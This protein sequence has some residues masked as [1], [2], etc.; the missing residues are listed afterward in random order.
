M[1]FPHGRRFSGASPPES[2]G[3]ETH[4]VCAEKRHE[5]RT[6]RDGGAP[7][8]SAASPPADC[9]MGTRAPA[10]LI[11][12]AADFEWRSLHV[13]RTFGGVRSLRQRMHI[14][15]RAGYSNT[16]TVRCIR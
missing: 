1:T 5:E 14:V 11:F 6:E 13:R 12:D 3:G 2:Q 10:A 9:P 16:L 7:D 15:T 4:E 8:H